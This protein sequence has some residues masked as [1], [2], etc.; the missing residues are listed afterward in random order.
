MENEINKDLQIALDAFKA[1]EYEKNHTNFLHVFYK[2]K[3]ALLS[4]RL[5]EEDI[6]IVLD[7]LV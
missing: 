5:S 7:L 1:Q 2:D 6:R 3:E 4:R